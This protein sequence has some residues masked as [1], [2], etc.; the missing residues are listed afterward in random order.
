[1][2]VTILASALILVSVPANA[3]KAQ[4]ICFDDGGVAD[5]QAGGN[6]NYTGQGASYT[7]KWKSVGAHQYMVNFDNGRTRVDTYDELGGGK[8]MDHNPQGATVPGHHC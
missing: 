3:G 2:K 1:M 7:G 6:Y 4:K 8:I 5:Y